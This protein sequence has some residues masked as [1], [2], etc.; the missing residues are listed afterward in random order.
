MHSLTWIFCIICVGFFPCMLELASIWYVGPQIC[1]YSLFTSILPPFCTLSFSVSLRILDLC[2]RWVFTATV[3]NTVAFNWGN[4]F[5]HKCKRPSVSDH[6]AVFDEQQKASTTSMLVWVLPE[7]WRGG[8]YSP[9]AACQRGGTELCLM[10]EPSGWCQFMMHWGYLS[11]KAICSTAPPPP[12]LQ[13]LTM[14]SIFNNLLWRE[15]FTILS[16][17][18][19]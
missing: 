3:P 7:T 10:G 8:A 4:I 19:W 12:H 18:I 5:L 14:A 13:H 6:S 2:C 9:T 17:L 16:Y 1:A 15:F 11:V